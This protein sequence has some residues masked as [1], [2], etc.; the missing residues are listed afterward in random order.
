MKNVVYFLLLF[1][2]F[3]LNGFCQKEEVY[4]K[5][6]EVQSQIP[7]SEN[8]F[9]EGLGIVYYS[10]G[11]VMKETPYVEGNR[12]GIEREYYENGRL[13]SEQPFNLDLKN[14]VYVGYFEDGGIKIRQDWENGKK[15]GSMHVYYPTGELRMYGLMENDSMIFAQ[16]FRTDGFL[17]TERLSYIAQ[18]I[19]T[20]Q[21]SEPQVF[22]KGKKRSLRTEKGNDV[23]IFIPRVP[24]RFISFA[25]PTGTIERS[26]DPR[27]PFTLTPLGDYKEFL[28]YLRIKTHSDAQPIMVRTLRIP[29]SGKD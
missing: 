15:E 19:D 18:P 4:Y 9:F 29:V 7:I 20:T 6:G 28:L 10:S 27:Y 8:G 11:E 26:N 23:S 24:S 25:S 22:I 12:Q 17:I 21:L 5:T 16:R 13:K 14:G 3:E 1:L 2:V